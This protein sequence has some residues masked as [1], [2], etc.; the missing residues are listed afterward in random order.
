MFTQTLQ[1]ALR[2]T[3]AASVALI[4]AVTSGCGS[5]KAEDFAASSSA[6]PIESASTPI[7]LNAAALPKGW[8]EVP[9]ETL[10]SDGT[11]PC[12]DALLGPGAPFDAADGAPVHVFA[13]SSLGAFLITA[14]A[15]ADDPMVALADVEQL[16]TGC[17]GQVDAAGFTTS[18]ETAD[19]PDVGEGAVAF[20]GAA[21][22]DRG[23]AVDYL[24][25][26]AQAGD[27][28][29]L[30]VQ[31]VALGELDPTLVADAAAAMAAQAG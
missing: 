21:A 29:I 25:V 10:G 4:L 11:G 22:D 30:V 17:D 27:A 6:T 15:R 18:I 16:V 9:T 13:Q 7:A 1:P 28:L 8:E 26:S 20:R 24:I 19:S 12:I 5:N 23:A 2:A 31:V 14:S 3:G